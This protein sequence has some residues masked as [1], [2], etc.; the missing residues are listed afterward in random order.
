MILNERDKIDRRN[1]WY[2]LTPEGE[3]DTNKVVKQFENILT[4]GFNQL[5]EKEGAHLV[6]ASRTLNVA[7]KKIKNSYV[8]SK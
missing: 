1:V 7:L 3:K 4:K 8:Q 6:D 5:N 2:S